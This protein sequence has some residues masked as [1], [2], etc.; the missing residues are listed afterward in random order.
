[1]CYAGAVADYLDGFKKYGK[2]IW[3]TEFNCWDQ[4]NITVDMQKSLMKGA[5]DHMDNDTMIYRYAWFIGRSQSAAST[6]DIFD[7][8]PGTL[9]ELGEIYFNYDSFH[10]TSEYKL[11]PGKIVAE[12]YSA[13]SGIQ[14][15]LTSDFEGMANVGWFDSGDWLQYNLDVPETDDYILYLRLASNSSTSIHVK[16]DDQLYETTQVPYT[17]GWQDWE[18]FKISVPLESGNTKLK[19]GS[20]EGGINVNWIFLSTEGNSKPL[21]DAGE[22]ITIQASQNT[23]T[24]SGSGSDQDGDK[25][26][27][28]WRK[29]SGSGG[30]IVSPDSLETEITGLLPGTYRFRLTAYDGIEDSADDIVVTVDQASA[31]LQRTTEGGIELYPNP[32]ANNIIVKGSLPGMETDVHVFDSCG[33]IVHHLTIESAVDNEL[34]L[35]VASLPPG[36]YLLRTISGAQSQ[37]L[38]FQK[39]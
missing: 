30:E 15:E 26:L 20:D 31:F 3:L 11:I 36:L 25:L 39:L 32:S 17:G 34:N 9:T 27:F 10:D 4:S 8:D 35:N 23:I 12:S 33:R 21:V 7:T 5:L 18:T 38:K 14:L 29:L 13:M 2:K 6:Y 24:L 16:I 19:L 28:S 37:C 22:D 1:M